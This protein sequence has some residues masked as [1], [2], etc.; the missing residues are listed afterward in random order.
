M[1]SLCPSQQQLPSVNLYTITRFILGIL[2]WHGVESE[3]KSKHRTE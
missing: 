2:L 1:P 3:L